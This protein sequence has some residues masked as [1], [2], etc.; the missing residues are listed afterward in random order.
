MTSAFSSTVPTGLGSTTVPSPGD[1]S[2]GYSSSPRTNRRRRGYCSGRRWW[3]I[4]AGL[5]SIGAAN[6]GRNAAESARPFTN[7]NIR[8]FRPGPGLVASRP[9]LDDAAGLFSNTQVTIVAG[10]VHNGCVEAWP[11]TSLLEAWVC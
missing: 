1:K 10:G 6:T 3:A 4:G 5:Q 9:F 7:G 2:L 8:R 11:K